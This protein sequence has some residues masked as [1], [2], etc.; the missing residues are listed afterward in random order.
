IDPVKEAEAWKIQI[1]GGA[2]T[3]SDWVSG[4]KH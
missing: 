2:A 1:R 4:R 3:E